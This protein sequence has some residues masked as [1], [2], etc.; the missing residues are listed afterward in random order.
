[1]LANRG[2]VR[3]HVIVLYITYRAGLGRILECGTFPSVWY[4]VALPSTSPVMKDANRSP[5]RW[6]QQVDNLKW[7]GLVVPMVVVAIA[8]MWTVVVV[9]EAAVTSTKVAAALVMPVVVIVAAATPVV[10]AAVRAAIA[11]MVVVAKR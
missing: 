8:A 5:L 10:V 1:M 7:G 6:V 4:R 2:L 11:S 3:R 9:V